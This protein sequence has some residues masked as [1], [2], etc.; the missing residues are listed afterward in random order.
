MFVHEYRGDLYLGRATPRYWLADG[1][2][3]GIERAA[4]HYGPLTFKI[5]SHAAEGT[6]KATLSALQRNR[7]NRIFVRLRH[8]Q[9]KPIQKVI[10]NGQPYDQFDAGKEWIILPGDIKGDIELTAQY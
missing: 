3:I 5:E 10:L 7:P 4:T 8:P 1:N 2:T 6:I 9:E